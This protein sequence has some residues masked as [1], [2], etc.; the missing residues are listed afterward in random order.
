MSAPGIAKGAPAG[1]LRRATPRRPKMTAA[2]TLR[3]PRGTF[4]GGHGAGTRLEEP[5]EASRVIMAICQH[6]SED[7]PQR[8]PTRQEAL[9]AVLGER[10]DDDRDADGAQCNDGSNHHGM[11]GPAPACHR[12][13]GSAGR[14]PHRELERSRASPAPRTGVARGNGDHAAAPLPHGPRARWAAGQP[15]A[16]APPHSRRWT[17]HRSR[18]CPR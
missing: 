3:G 8:Q 15:T 5:T 17:D 4:T 13:P 7:K 11:S 9:V 2:T 16:A 6:E 12:W 18:R 1:A 10:F 14:R